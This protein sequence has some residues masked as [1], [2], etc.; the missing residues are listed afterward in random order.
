M[1]YK[2]VPVSTAAKQTAAAMRNKKY[3]KQKKLTQ[4]SSPTPAWKNF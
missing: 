3:A 2:T 4:P 1:D